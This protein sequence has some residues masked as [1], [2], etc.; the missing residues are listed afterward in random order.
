MRKVLVA[1]SSA[2]VLTAACSGNQGSPGSQGTAGAQGVTGPQGP[3]GAQGPAG[4]PDT[5]QQVLAKLLTVDGTGSSLDADRLDGLPASA[6]QPVFTQATLGS[7]LMLASPSGLLSIDPS[8]VQL[9]VAGSC[10]AGSTIQSIDATGNVT[11]AG[12]LR[13]VIVSPA[14]TPA[15]SGAA[16]IAA[17]NG[18]SNPSDSNPWLVKLE[19]GA[20]ALSG[21]L[22]LPG[23]V[24]LAGSGQAATQ[25]TGSQ[26]LIVAAGSGAN[27]VRDLTL[28]LITAQAGFPA[29]DHDGPGSMAVRNVTVSVV[30]SAPA[31][32]GPG[33][34][35]VSAIT[36]SASAA[37]VI[38]NSTVT[39]SAT[40]RAAIGV[41]AGDS[42]NPGIQIDGSHVIVSGN[43]ASR[44]TA[45]I[46]SLVSSPF[47]VRSSDL[48]ATG[49]NAFAAIG[50]LSTVNTQ[51][52]APTLT[53]GQ[54]KC[55]NDYKADFSAVSTAC[56]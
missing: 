42:A 5:A 3:T 33:D 19:P 46:S 56:N 49:T 17:V 45:A 35:A 15:A 8:A 1:A 25:I 31:A 22:N 40:S 48:H 53:N 12:L 41:F 32:S 52:D 50:S 18:L 29:L 34:F 36:D 7:G 14:S 44:S 39:V 11:C 54:A 9:R 37:L 47:V 6:F 20:Y 2:L 10:A 55:I 30:D 23:G 4:S 24:T 43:D 26:Q 16:L 13:T 28:S 51:L 38:E 21:T 27:E